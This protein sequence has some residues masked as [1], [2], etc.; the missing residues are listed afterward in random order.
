MEHAERHAFLQYRGHFVIRERIS[1]NGL[2]LVTERLEGVR[3]VAIGV[4][5]KVGSLY[6]EEEESGMSHFIEHMLFKGTENRTGREITHRMDGLGAE[7]NAYTSKECTVVY[8]K[9]LDEHIDTAL[10]IL[11]DMVFHS[12]FDEKEIEKEK[13]VI[14]DELKMYEDSP[15]DRIYDLLS[16]KIFG[17]HSL[18]RPILGLESSMMAFGREALVDFYRRFYHPDNMVISIAG[19]FDEE[20]IADHVD[21][22]FEKE[23]QHT[24]R[25]PH[26][27]A[28]GYEWGMVHQERDL[29]Q[30]HVSLGFEGVPFD[31]QEVY[32]LVVLDNILGGNASSR[33]FQRLRE[34]EA[35]TYTI[36]SQPS[37]YHEIG[38]YSLYFSVLPDKLHIATDVLVD[39][40]RE[41]ASGDFNEE[42][43][44]RSKEQLKGSYILSLE[45][46]EE[47]MNMIGKN[48]LLEGRIKTPDEIVDKI[49]AVTIET[50]R[51]IAQK[52][53]DHERFVLSLV[54]PL[55]AQEAKA[56]HERIKGGMKR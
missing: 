12:A 25:P 4:W 31:A 16:E 20:T 48:Y 46:T 52:V 32:A 47:I 53:L 29:E 36:Y 41:I 24:F 7:L 26:V 30:V 2:R 11:S 5:I 40:L 38:I 1:N 44:H 49:D 23:I 42:E 33:L 3:S 21:R 18:A 10:D 13:S 14:L 50:V 45:G 51:S 6:E 27:T 34:D 55:D 37:F 35:L 19:S 22:Y 8:A 39:V 9:V 17:G 28:P 15:E 54:G 43:I 56:L